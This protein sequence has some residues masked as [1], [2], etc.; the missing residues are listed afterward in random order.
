MYSEP[1]GMTANINMLAYLIILFNNKGWI[2]TSLSLWVRRSK[3]QIFIGCLGVVVVVVVMIWRIIHCISSHIHPCHERVISQPSHCDCCH[4]SHWNSVCFQFTL[5]FFSRK[6]WIWT[7]PCSALLWNWILQCFP[8]LSFSPACTKLI[9]SNW[10]SKKSFEL[11]QVKI[12]GW[13]PSLR[14]F[15]EHCWSIIV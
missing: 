4:L 14:D 6:Q 3:P 15:N 7:P 12:S 9:P 1:I 13:M 2:C 5:I 8:V 10:C 11:N